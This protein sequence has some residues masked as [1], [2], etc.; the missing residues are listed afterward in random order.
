[1]EV[2]RSIEFHR[3]GIAQ[4]IRIQGSKLGSW[5]RDGRLDST[6]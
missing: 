2:R 4:K 3:L 1:M 6:V 5:K